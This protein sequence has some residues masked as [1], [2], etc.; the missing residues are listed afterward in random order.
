MA[1][2]LE[3]DGS[4]GGFPLEGKVPPPCSVGRCSQVTSVDSCCRESCRKTGRNRPSHWK[5]LLGGMGEEVKVIK[6]LQFFFE[7]EICCCEFVQFL[8]E[9]FDEDHGGCR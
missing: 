5:M 4:G 6:Y 1:D 9:S 2:Y 8:V 3:V 7:A